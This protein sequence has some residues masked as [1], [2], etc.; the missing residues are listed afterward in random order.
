MKAITEY[1]IGFNFS[2]CS[3]S[4]DFD[5]YDTLDSNTKSRDDIEKLTSKNIRADSAEIEVLTEFE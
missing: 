3:Y 5:D 1:V 4:K 2:I